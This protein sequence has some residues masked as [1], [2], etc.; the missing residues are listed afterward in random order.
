MKERNAQTIEN[1]NLFNA[2]ERE[3]L[4]AAKE[5]L[6]NGADVNYKDNEGNT[7]LLE[8]SFLGNIELIKLLV[9][10]G[11]DTNVIFQDIDT[12]LTLSI[13]KYYE[14]KNLD[15]IEFL[16]E[17]GANVNHKDNDG[18]SIL[19]V[20]LFLFNE[21]MQMKLYNERGIKLSKVDIKKLI[22]FFI[23]KGLNVNHIYESNSILPL[24]ISMGNIDAVKLLLDNGVNVNHKNN[25]DVSVLMQSLVLLN[26]KVIEKIISDTDSQVEISKIDIKNLINLVISKGANIND[27][28]Q[29][30]SILYLM[31]L[32][33]N[34]DAVKLLLDN[35]VKSLSGKN[36]AVILFLNKQLFKIINQGFADFQVVFED[37]DKNR[38]EIV[39]LLINDGV[40]LNSVF[41]SAIDFYFKKYEIEEDRKY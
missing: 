12:P 34:I 16:I 25:F 22:N 3:D 37:F 18:F 21:T 20:L 27:T 23:L 28:C 35:G 6:C 11:A 13:D 24:M 41:L 26:R 15:I 19:V 9:K 39:E 40:D 33:G 29:S 2:I 36:I 10:N 17:N 1:E 7:A 4:N 30:K 5:A 32:M 31:A 38:L 8:A 14:T